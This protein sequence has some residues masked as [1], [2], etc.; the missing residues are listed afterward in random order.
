MIDLMRE[1]KT[2][3]NA[4]AETL[5][6]HKISEKTA[7]LASV[8]KVSHAILDLIFTNQDTLAAVLETSPHVH[9]ELF[10]PK[11]HGHLAPTT[12][13]LELIVDTLRNEKHDLAK[14]M[15]LH[16]FFI[17]R[18]HEHCSNKDDPKKEVLVAQIF[19][20]DLFANRHREK[21]DHPKEN[22]TPGVLNNATL[23]KKMER[24]GI[25][26]PVSSPKDHFKLGD[27]SRFFK[28]A[29]QHN[30]PVA[31]DV[32]GHTGSLLL[33]ALLYGNLSQPELK[34]YLTAAFSFLTLARAHTFHEV[35]IVGQTVGLPFSFENYNEHLPEQLRSLS[36]L[37]K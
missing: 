37:S 10:S 5:L 25:H 28:N 26:K 4:C 11:I 9:T 20:N 34:E 15:Q 7:E 21:I 18:L 32:S 27:S 36:P 33:G 35:M 16:A 13:I 22:L 31:C 24:L 1:L 23:A 12:N 6:A 17:Y 19:K 29:Q 30:L 14:I 8:H 2:E 3:L